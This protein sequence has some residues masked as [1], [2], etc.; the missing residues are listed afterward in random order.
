[1]QPVKVEKLWTF[2][3]IELALIEDTSNVSVPPFE[4][5]KLLGLIEGALIDEKVIDGPIMLEKEMELAL[6]VQM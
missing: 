4:N 2:A 5:E 6:I 1:M 3:T